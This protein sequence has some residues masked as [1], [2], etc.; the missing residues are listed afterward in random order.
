[1]IVK[2]EK[3]IYLDGVTGGMKENRLCSWSILDETIGLKMCFN[4]L[5]PNA[6]LILQS[7]SFLFSGPLKLGLTLEKSDPTANKFLFEYKMENESVRSLFI[8]GN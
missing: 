5:L 4:Y 7:P 6:S 1:M 3:V 2:G 8:H